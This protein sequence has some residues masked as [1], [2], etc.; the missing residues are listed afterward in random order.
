MATL[1]R[2]PAVVAGD[3]GVA[4]ADW[5]QVATGIASFAIATLAFAIAWRQWRA[6]ERLERE[7]PAREAV[8][9][10]FSEPL[11]E[12]RFAMFDL[13]NEVSRAAHGAQGPY[14]DMLRREFGVD[15]RTVNL[16]ARYELTVRWSETP[17]SDEQARVVRKQFERQAAI[18]CATFDAILKAAESSPEATA[19][20]RRRIGRLLVWWMLFWPG[21]FDHSRSF[22]ARRFLDTHDVAGC[23]PADPDCEAYSEL[24]RNAPLWDGEQWQGAID[25]YLDIRETMFPAD[26]RLPLRSSELATE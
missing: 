16:P 3:E 9:R 18:I 5:A 6:T 25:N 7:R 26:P 8:D 4:W 15:R 1:G 17:P 21:A 11:A 22:V 24:F 10:F 12:I 20:V 23:N 14:F 2:Q 19:H 13:I